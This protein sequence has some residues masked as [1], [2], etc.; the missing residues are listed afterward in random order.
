VD[1]GN[2]LRP[3]AALIGLIFGALGL[4][5][6]CG[7]AETGRDAVLPGGELVVASSG[8]VSYLLESKSHQVIIRSSKGAITCD[9]SVDVARS[10]R[11]LKT[12]TKRAPAAKGSDL[13]LDPNLE[14]LGVL[15]AWARELPGGGF[16][17]RQV[18]GD[19]MSRSAVTAVNSILAHCGV[20][21]RL[22]PVVIHE[23]AIVRPLKPL[24]LSPSLV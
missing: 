19:V 18:T 1:Y 12:L 20:K 4:L 7:S 13:S 22:H 17:V 6:A 10:W 8:D 23:G 21:T 15:V 5:A 14:S 24:H 2:S 3:A 16:E 9:V 11:I